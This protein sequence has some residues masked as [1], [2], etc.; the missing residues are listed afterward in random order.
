[1]LFR[2]EVLS[3]QEKRQYDKAAELWEK[4]LSKNNNF[5]MAYLGIGKNLLENEEYEKAMTYFELINNKTYYGQAFKL[6]REQI[7]EK[8]GL[9]I[10][11][12]F[13]V[14]LVL[15]IFVFKKIN[16]HN[17]KVL[18]VRASGKLSDQLL[19]VFFLLAHPLQAFWGLKA[20]K[21]GSV[22]SASIILAVTMVSSVVANLGGSY[23]KDTE[24]SLTAS[25]TIIL[26][27]LLFV[28]CNMCFTSLM[29]GKGTFKDVYIAVCYSSAPYALLTIPCTLIS[30]LLVSDE[31]GIL[32]MVSTVVI[33]W[34][35]MLIFFGSMTVHEYSFGKNILVCLLTL[36]GIVFLLFIVLVFISLSGQ[37]IS[38]IGSIASEL[39]YRM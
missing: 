32:G 22:K 29:D 28:L 30:Y 18:E 16:K 6:Y 5:D 1:M 11:A 39:N 21:R 36:V 33:C 19:Y 9:L 34:M 7:L 26:G 35:I 14:L 13:V 27:L 38:A 17:N 4:I 3:L 24:G 31:L 8:Y 23:L 15:V 2:S 37:M 12:I 10:F 25:L 20:E